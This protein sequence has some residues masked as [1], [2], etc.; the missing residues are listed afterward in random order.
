MRLGPYVDMVNEAA[1]EIQGL[2]NR[3]NNKQVKEGL[4]QISNIGQ[5]I[6]EIVNQEVNQLTESYQELYRIATRSEIQ[7]PSFDELVARMN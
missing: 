3:A 1:V 6:V 4:T 2:I 5:Q 7:I